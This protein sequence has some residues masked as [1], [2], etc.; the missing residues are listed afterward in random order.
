LALKINP[1]LA[2]AYNNLAMLTLKQG[3]DKS[4]ALAWAKDA[5][6][7][8]PDVP[9]FYDTLGWAYRALG[10][11]ANA[12]ASLER[13][14]QLPPPQATIFYRLGIVYQ[15]NNRAADALAAFRQ[16][17]QIQ[18]DFPDAQQAKRYIQA[19]SK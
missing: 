9:H 10:D 11:S 8:N 16:A 7:L 17:L 5:V 18:Q 4:R 15:E 6:R 12:I 19:L 3:G 1:N 14:S 2:P 13:A